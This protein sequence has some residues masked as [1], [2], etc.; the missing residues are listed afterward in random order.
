[1]QGAANKMP[2]AGAGSQKDPIN[3]QMKNM[4]SK[5]ARLMQLV[6]RTNESETAVCSCAFLTLELV[7]IMSLPH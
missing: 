6:S 1:M 5:T 3:Q 7:S 2:P 4:K